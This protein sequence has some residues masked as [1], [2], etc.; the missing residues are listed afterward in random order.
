MKTKILSLLVVVFIASVSANA[1][2][3]DVL[4]TVPEGEH[5]TASITINAPSTY[6][7]YTIK[8]CKNGDPSFGFVYL[9]RANIY[10]LT[11]NTPSVSFWPNSSVGSVVNSYEPSGAN[12]Q[13]VWL[14]SNLPPG[15]YTVEY[16]GSGVVASESPI[17]TT[18][19]LQSWLNYWF[20]YEFNCPPTGG[21]TT[22]VWHA[23]SSMSVLLDSFSSN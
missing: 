19:E 22:T 20:Q 2:T 15:E 21:Y 14:L 8:L 5:G 3:T 1:A 18:Q 7:A 17:T 13:W 23:D 6:D 11:W 9:Q 10:D 16:D 12:K 4:F